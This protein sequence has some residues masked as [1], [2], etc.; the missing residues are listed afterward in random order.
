MGATCASNLPPLAQLSVA[1]ADTGG[2]RDVTY[3]ASVKNES[4]GGPLSN[5][6][7]VYSGTVGPFVGAFGPNDNDLVAP[8]TVVVTA[9]DSA[10]NVSRAVATGA[11][12]R[13]VPPPPTTTT[14]TTIFIF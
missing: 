10:G 4:E 1:V 5:V 3:Q 8:I 6:D 2:V 9:T 7:E 11:L 14:T 12:V 13:C